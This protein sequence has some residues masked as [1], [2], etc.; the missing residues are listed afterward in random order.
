MLTRLW[1]YADPSV[2]SSEYLLHASVIGMV[3]FD[4]DIFAAGNCYDEHQYKDYSLFCPYAFRLPDGPI[5]AKNLAIEYKYMTNTSEW[6]FIARKSAE[7]IIKNHDQFRK[8][9]SEIG[10]LP[11]GGGGVSCWRQLLGLEISV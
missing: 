2:L 3:E 6:F 7:R 5:L 4:D 9:K 8:G 10:L 1:K 11:G